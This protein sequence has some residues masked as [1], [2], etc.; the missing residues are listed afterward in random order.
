MVIIPQCQWIPRLCEESA[1][2]FHHKTERLRPVLVRPMDVTSC[3]Q[4]LKTE[5]I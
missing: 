1:V 3:G 2:V 4:Y 5:L